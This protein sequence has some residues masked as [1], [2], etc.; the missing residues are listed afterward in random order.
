MERIMDISYDWYKVFY[1][2]AK[3]GNFSHAAKVLMN[4]QPNL[5][6]TVKNLEAA[7]GCP[8]FLRTNRGVF[9][10]PEGKI[11]YERIKVAVENIKEGETR[12]SESRDM[13]NG[14]VFIAASEVAL[15]CFLLPV[16]KQYRQQYPGIRLRISNHS[17][18]Q[19]LSEIVGGN[20]DIAV[21]TTPTETYSS[22]EEIRIK[23]LREIAVRSS[24]FRIPEGRKLSLAELASFPMISLGHGT[25]S[26]AFY[27]EFFAEHG[28]NYRAETEAATSDQIIPMVKAGLGIGF[29]P[30]EMIEGEDDIKEIRLE[31]KIP[32]R[33]VCLVKRREQP[34][35]VAAREMVRMI[36]ENAEKGL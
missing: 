2:V 27:S 34:L 20:A 17:T 23:P 32:E 14:S 13:T 35:S 10:T 22:L 15:R 36:T 5:T 12:L 4:N 16:L 21:V 7:L 19:A 31:E 18:P 25:K 9:L 33:F 3:Y 29:L 1:Y 6:R 28:L 30:K 8:L 24:D 11:L 26:Y